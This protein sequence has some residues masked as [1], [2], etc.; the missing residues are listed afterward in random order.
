M[1]TRLRSRLFFPV[2]LPAALATLGGCFLAGGS[3]SVINQFEPASVDGPEDVKKLA[4]MSAPNMFVQGMLPLLLVETARGLGNPDTDCPK[5]TEEGNTVTI[6]GGCTTASGAKIYGKATQTR[7]GKFSFTSGAAS[8]SID[9]GEVVYQDFGLEADQTCDDG[10]KKKVTMKANGTMKSRQTG[11][12]AYAFDIDIVVKGDLLDEE[13]CT[14]TPDGT[15]AIVYS[16]T[17]TGENPDAEGRYQKT[18]WNGSGRMGSTDLGRASATT[19]DEVYDVTVCERE[20]ASGTTRIQAAKEV[21]I[22][23]DGATDC[24]PDATV[25]WSLDGAE[26][27]TLT[28]VGCT[29]G[30]GRAA[31]L[32]LLLVAGWFLGRSRRKR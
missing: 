15:L 21:V 3:D 5:K 12:D 9:L 30:S 8:G 26:Q 24:S 14:V 32:S 17:F 4:Q 7:E 16:G 29:S 18:T 22:T 19:T 23:Y 27:G 31:P 20:A 28:G 6:E 11:T 10:T 2:L 13:T 1:H 25:T